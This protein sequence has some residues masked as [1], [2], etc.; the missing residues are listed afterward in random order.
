MMTKRKRIKN[1][2]MMKNEGAGDYLNA[3][4]VFFSADGTVARAVKA[5]AVAR[6]GMA[7]YETVLAAQRTAAHELRSLHNKII[8]CVGRYVCGKPQEDGFGKDMAEHLHD[9]HVFLLGLLKEKFGTQ[10]SP[11]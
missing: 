11:R 7:G 8:C 6:P 9:I 2:A 4:E 1:A 3:L 5:G 10:S